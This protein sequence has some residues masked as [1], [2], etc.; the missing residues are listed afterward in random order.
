MKIIINLNFQNT[1]QN[2]ETNVEIEKVKLT[3]DEMNF[4]FL[5]EIN[6]LKNKLNLSEEKIKEKD[7][8]INDLKEKM[9]QLKQEQ[10]TKIPHILKLKL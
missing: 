3:K 9:E 4:I 7:N 10:E 5:K 1:T 2:I 8:E 6:S